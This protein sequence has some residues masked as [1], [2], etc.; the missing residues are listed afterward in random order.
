M[1]RHSINVIFSNVYVKND[2]LI[3]TYDKSL[4]KHNP[5]GPAEIYWGPKYLLSEVHFY[6]NNFEHRENGPS[7][8][9]WDSFGKVDFIAHYL[10]GEPIYPS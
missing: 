3:I 4:K 9:L 5:N 2:H 1:I 8:V 10:H 6:F 7:M